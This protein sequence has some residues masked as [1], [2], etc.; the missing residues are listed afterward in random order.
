MNNE[1]SFAIFNMS[2]KIPVESDWFKI[3]VIGDNMRGQ[4]FF[5]N[6]VDIL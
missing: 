6:I 2:G 3:K 5:I 4:F 1:I